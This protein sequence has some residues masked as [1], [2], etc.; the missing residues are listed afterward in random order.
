MK[1]AE[2]LFDNK[3]SPRTESVVAAAV[4]WAERIMRKIDN[5]FGNQSS[6]VNGYSLLPFIDTVLQCFG[7]KRLMSSSDWPVGLVA[8]TYKRWIDAVERAVTSLSPSER[9]RLFGGTAK[10]AYRL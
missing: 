3:P 10:E 7:P 1:T 4:Q 8:C 2:D 5:V 9:N 6:L